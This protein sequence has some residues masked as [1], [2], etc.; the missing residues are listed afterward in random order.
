MDLENDLKSFQS[1]HLVL[2][3]NPSMPA[4]SKNHASNW[5]RGDVIVSS[6]FMLDTG[7]KNHLAW[8]V[9]L[10][11]SPTEKTRK[12]YIDCYCDFGTGT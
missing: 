12:V 7:D 6:I 5:G 1:P 8:I 2:Y 3:V 9:F 10:K 4:I 11:S